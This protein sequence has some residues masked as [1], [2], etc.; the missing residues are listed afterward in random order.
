[1]AVSFLLV[2]FVKNASGQFSAFN[3]KNK[4][5]LGGKGEGCG[6]QEALEKIIPLHCEGAAIH[7]SFR[8]PLKGPI[9][10]TRPS[11]PSEQRA[12]AYY[13]VESQTSN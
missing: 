12:F 4:G 9:L 11:L 5:R 1:M 8:I 13:N 10:P 2:F 7:S 6:S 3:D